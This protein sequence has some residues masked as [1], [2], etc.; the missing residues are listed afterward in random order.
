MIGKHRCSDVSHPRVGTTRTRALRAVQQTLTN[1]PDESK[2][3]D[4]RGQVFRRG[5][6]RTTLARVVCHRR[7]CHLQ[8]QIDVTVL[9]VVVTLHRQDE[10]N[11]PKNGG[12]TGVVVTVHRQIDEPN[13]MKRN[14]GAF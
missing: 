9:V 2:S 3:G 10:L 7:S 13:N 11:N 4:I 12:V 5:C 6:H 14:G 1:T 8:R